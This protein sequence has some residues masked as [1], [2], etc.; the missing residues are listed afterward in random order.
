MTLFGCFLY[1]SAY[2]VWID[3]FKIKFWLTLW[4]KIGGK[5]CRT[6]T[7]KKYRRLKIIL[8]NTNIKDVFE[9][10]IK[11]KVIL[12]LLHYNFPIVQLWQHM[13][14]NISKRTEGHL[15]SSFKRNKRPLFQLQNK[16]KIQRS[17]LQ[18]GDQLSLSFVKI[19]G[20]EVKAYPL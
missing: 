16:F 9:D 15:I 20:S 10:V 13:L 18:N 14:W 3:F 12:Q 7:M 4:R 1:V 2:L 6:A 19:R 5:S 11:T 17:G 8:T